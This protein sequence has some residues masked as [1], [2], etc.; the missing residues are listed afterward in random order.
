MACALLG[1]NLAVVQTIGYSTFA[2]IFNVGWAATQ[3]SHM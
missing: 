2:A 3:V 1:G